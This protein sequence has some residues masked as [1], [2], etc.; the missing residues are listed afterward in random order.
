MPDPKD[1]IDL[2]FAGGIRRLVRIIRRPDPPMT[3]LAEVYGGPQ[4]AGFRSCVGADI[5][6]KGV[7]LGFACRVAT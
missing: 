1:G 5:D 3:T 2:G 7:V 4:M 6:S